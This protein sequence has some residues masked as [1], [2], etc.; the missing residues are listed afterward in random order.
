M[1]NTLNIPERTLAQLS[2][3]T[4]SINIIGGT[5]GRLSAYQPLVVRVTDS[6]YDNSGID[7]D[8]DNMALFQ[9]KRH[10]EPWVLGGNKDMALEHRVV[11]AD[12]DPVT[13]A[14]DPKV[15]VLFPNFDY[16]TFE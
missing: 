11:Q 5:G 4:N 13:N 15:T 14:T 6:D 16:S 8:A 2:E 7:N 1:A 3:S 9:S 10:G 12:A